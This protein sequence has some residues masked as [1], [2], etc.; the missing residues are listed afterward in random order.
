M[1]SSVTVSND[2]NPD[3]R[4]TPGVS[5]TDQVFLLSISEAEKYFSSDSARE[6][7]FRTSKDNRKCA[8]WLRTPGSKLNDAAEIGINGKIYTYG[9]SVS[10]SN[11]IAVRPALWINLGS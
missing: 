11:L 7:Y 9:S 4:I 3:F 2:K 1:I 8:W 10:L 5:T 6:C